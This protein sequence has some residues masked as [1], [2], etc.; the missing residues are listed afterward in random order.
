M[1]SGRPHCFAAPCARTTPATEHSSVMAS[2]LYPKQ[3]ACR[4]SSSGC[5]APRRNE[6]LVRACSSAYTGIRLLREHAVQIPTPGVPLLKHPP[7][8]TPGVACDVIIARHVLAIPPTALDALGA[9][10]ENRSLLTQLLQV[11]RERHRLIQ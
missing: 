9:F 11:S 5:E 8:G 1:M 2:A 6:K 4:T 10:L 3:D 7:P